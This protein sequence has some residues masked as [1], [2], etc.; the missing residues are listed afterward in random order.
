MNFDFSDDA[1]SMRESARRFLDANAGPAVARRAMNGDESVGP[2]LW[3]QVVE[4]G[5]TAARVPEEL[6][7]RDRW[8]RH[9][10]FRHPQCLGFVG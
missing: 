10:W 8:G 3:K 9:G 7:L 6:C 1:K 2:N 5:W 4:L